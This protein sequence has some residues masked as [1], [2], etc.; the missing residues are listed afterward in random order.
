MGHVQNY[1]YSMNYV[2]QIM[3]YLSI[4][5]VLIHKLEQF[6]QALDILSTVHLPITLAS[7]T[8]LAHMPDQVKTALHKTNQDYILLFPDLY[9][10]YNIQ[11]VSCRYDMDFNFLL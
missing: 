11:L 1:K 4:Y 3:L 9:Y 7:P 2:G 10:Y 8:Q 6:I 5:E